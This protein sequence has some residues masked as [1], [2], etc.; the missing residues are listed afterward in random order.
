[1]T[2]SS[3]PMFVQPNT[4]STTTSSTQSLD[5]L[6]Y[7]LGR[8]LGDGMSFVYHPTHSQSPLLFN[9]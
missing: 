1:M 8:I 2:A 4:S 7:H 5:F 9:L 6:R 3:P